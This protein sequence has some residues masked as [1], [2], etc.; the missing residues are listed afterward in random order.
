MRLTA[1]LGAL[2]AA[3]LATATPRTAHIY[4][5][6]LQGRNAKPS[7]LAEIAYDVATP[8]TAEVLTYEV[9]EL[10]DEAATIRVGL[11]DV[12]TQTWTSGTTVASVANFDKGFSPNFLVSV[13]GAGDVVSVTLKG[14]GI[15]A[16][17]T[18]DFGP[19]MV[20]L[21]ETRGTQPALNKPVV[22]NP[23]GKREEVQEKTLLQKYV[24]SMPCDVRDTWKGRCANVG[25]QVLVGGCD[26]VVHGGERR[27]RRRQIDELEREIHNTR[28]LIL[29]DFTWTYWWQAV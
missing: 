29:H 10:P 11:Y 28:A 16:G 19:K 9:P 18:R 24:F 3:T 23:E 21:T 14:V 1:L 4:V 2:C 22:L 17:H 25:L 7:P 6:S 26:C 12:R 27:R 8:S 5:Q 15:D 20:L 13:D